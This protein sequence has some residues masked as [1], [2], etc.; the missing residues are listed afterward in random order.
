MH[1]SK[2]ING[3]IKYDSLSQALIQNCQELHHP[4]NENRFESLLW[5]L[6]H[7][8]KSP[9]MAIDIETTNLINNNNASVLN[10][11]KLVNIR[12]MVNDIALILERCTMNA[13][14][15]ETTIEPSSF[16]LNLLIE[17]LVRCFQVSK[18]ETIQ[19]WQGEVKTDYLLLKM[20]I[21]NLISNAIKYGA[22]E[23]SIR[24]EVSAAFPPNK[25]IDFLVLN[26]TGDV[27]PP[28]PEQV[29]KKNYRSDSAKVLPG[30]GHG[31]WLCKKFS[32]W[33]GAEIELIIKPQSTCFKL[34]LPHH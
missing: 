27:E 16:K 4:L 33:L 1:K 2:V 22:H 11:E 12:L 18:I 34:N 28:D 3:A 13:E 24:L 5:I 19:N 23:A 14:S 20:I 21:M 31:L 9:I 29:F 30:R 6:L 26:Q 32:E 25:G 17:E 15:H 8:L 10:L 7:E